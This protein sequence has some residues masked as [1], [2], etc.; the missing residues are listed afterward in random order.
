MSVSK[1]RDAMYFGAVLGLAKL[2]DA[3]TPAGA[4]RE[5]A[6]PRKPKANKIPAVPQNPMAPMPLGMQPPMP[7]K[8]A[9]LDELAAKQQA[10]QA[11]LA[12]AAA[13]QAE[14]D[15][16]KA[17]M[18]QRTSRSPLLDPTNLAL[19]GI[20]GAGLYG[21]YRALRPR[22]KRAADLAAAPAVSP[23]AQTTDAN[24]LRQAIIAEQDAATLYAQS[25]D[26]TPN[27][28]LQTLFDDVAREEKVHAG[29]FEQL[30]GRADQQYPAAIQ[31]GKM[32]AQT[33]AAA[34]GAQFAK[35]AN[36]MDLA[37]TLQP[38]NPASGQLNPSA[39][40]GSKGPSTAEPDFDRQARLTQ[41]IRASMAKRRK[42]QGPAAPVKEAALFGAALATR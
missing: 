28:G 19:L 16:H 40:C 39:V 4:L 26:S 32:E 5:H 11:E 6:S 21:A 1:N 34:F 22:T 9:A 15:R 2:A 25:A 20:G 36:T 7:A 35:K 10:A 14:Y 31:E 27:H 13:M 17:E 23:E 29:E 3:S 41:A 38:P 18:Q 37:G 30:L 42:P 33:K 24:L 8:T 12:S